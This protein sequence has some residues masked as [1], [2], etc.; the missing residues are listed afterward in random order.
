M[1]IR[2]DVVDKVVEI[3]LDRI[4]SQMGKDE[5]KE[6]VERI[7]SKLMEEIFSGI[8]KED[9]VGILENAIEEIIK[10]FSGKL[11][12]EE[13]ISILKNITIR[14]IDE[15]G[16][17]IVK[18]MFDALEKRDLMELMPVVEKIKKLVFILVRTFVD[19]IKGFGK[20]IYESF[21][22]VIIEVIP[23][24]VRSAINLIIRFIEIFLSFM[25]T[26]M[27]T[28]KEVVAIRKELKVD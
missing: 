25:T 28:M 16:K 20:D 11:S 2:D 22:N 14:V 23:G 8:E 1:G 12:T 17:R 24:I 13:K 19:L 21:K 6:M 7:S 27:E 15:V 5:K 9:R 26:T 18:I 10:N 4:F 3:T